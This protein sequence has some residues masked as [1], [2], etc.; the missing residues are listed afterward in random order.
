METLILYLPIL[1]FLLV[2]L[3]SIHRCCHKKYST[4]KTVV[5]LL[6]FSAL[7]YSFAAFVLGPS[8]F[9]GDGSRIWGGFLYLIPLRLL[10]REKTPLLF[11][12]ICTCCTYTMGVLAI[13]IQA[14]NL[15]APEFQFCTLI[16]ETII[17]LIT[18]YPFY[19][20]ILPRYVFTI[21][22]MTVFKAGQSK[23]VLFNNIFTFL[24][25]TFIHTVFLQSA[26]SILKIT[27]LVL[28]MATG[29]ISYYILYRVINDSL[30]MNQLE[31]DALH[32]P[33]TGLGNRSYL[34]NHL[35]N[36]IETGQTFS[37][38]FMD[39]DRFK[40]VN[41]QYGHIVGDAYLKHFSDIISNLFAGHGK[42]FR[43]GGDEF[44]FVY[45]GI[46]PQAAV[47]RLKKCQEWNNGA[48]C[49]FNQVSTGVL[50][51]QPPHEDVEQ[52]L[53]KVDRLMYENKMHGRAVRC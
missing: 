52:I 6:I 2:N 9:S 1:E 48:P 11:I 30:K 37:I 22:N 26:A 42:P 32:D 46:V 4:A 33:L 3:F 13:S 25:L 31:H 7:F 23:Y 24:T 8:I 28:M 47:D 39:L 18:F 34:W 29:Y 19:K 43:F 10:Y 35:Y 12:I 5:T 38:L 27:A 51:C 49:P 14:S 41:D 45:N 16:I 40:Q 44:I 50:L 21:E 15:I 53:H 20:G 36:L 17:F